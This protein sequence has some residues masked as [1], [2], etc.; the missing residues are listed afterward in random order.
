MDHMETYGTARDCMKLYRD[1]MGLHGILWDR[2]G[3]HRH[4]GL[5]E[6]L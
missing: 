3:L 1:R 5:D 4:W 2:M 6:T